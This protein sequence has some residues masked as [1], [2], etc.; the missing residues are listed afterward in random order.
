MAS[1]WGRKVLIARFTARFRKIASPTERHPAKEGT[2]GGKKEIQKVNNETQ[3]NH[4]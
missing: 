2:S 4:G 3:D 1:P